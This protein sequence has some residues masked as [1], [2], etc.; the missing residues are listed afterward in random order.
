MI[1]IDIYQGV[2]FPN[3]TTSILALTGSNSPNYA[4]YRSATDP[5]DIRIVSAAL[6]ERGGI[7]RIVEYIAQLVRGGSAAAAVAREAVP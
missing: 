5:N 3:V 7:L 6:G 2:K 4:I 1:F